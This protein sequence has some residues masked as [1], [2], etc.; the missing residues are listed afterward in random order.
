MSCRK[1][2][3]VENKQVFTISQLMYFK[4]NHTVHLFFPTIPVMLLE[5]FCCMP[6]FVH[7]GP[8]KK[9]FIAFYQ[10]LMLS[11]C[12]LCGEYFFCLKFYKF[13][14]NQVEKILH[15]YSFFLLRLCFMV[16]ISFH[17]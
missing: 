14:F 13:S 7:Y 16:A 4:I 5:N 9:S 1:W 12:L 15:Q 17:V 11:G 10:S 6:T 8:L 2:C 3:E